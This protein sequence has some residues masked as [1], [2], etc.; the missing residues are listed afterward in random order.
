MA[1]GEAELQSVQTTLDGGIITLWDHCIACWPS[2]QL[3]IS[4]LLI[5]VASG[6]SHGQ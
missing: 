1:T 4:L 6:R 5:F 2:S 3:T